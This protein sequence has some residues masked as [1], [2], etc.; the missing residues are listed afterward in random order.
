MRSCRK[1]DCA[2]IWKTN[3]W[4]S[5]SVT[6]GGGIKTRT[7]TCIAEDTGFV[8][9]SAQCARKKTKPDLVAPCNLLQ[10]VSFIWEID[11]EGR[12]SKTCGGGYKLRIVYCKNKQ[13]RVVVSNSYCDGRP[14]PARIV[15]CNNQMCPEL[16]WHTKSLTQCSVTCGNG[17]KF[18]EVSCV[19]KE[20]REK[21]DDDSCHGDRPA[22]T[23]ACFDHICDRL[24]IQLNV[25][26]EDN[27]SA[28]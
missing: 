11:L 1:Q 19:N 12:C 9:D 20:T 21:V 22:E 10:C 17:T 4:S 27:L 2:K 6:C 23:V 16:V 25:L 24:V 5:C 15:Q 14:S 3:E 28:I 26:H 13:T 7:V 8:T 18:Q